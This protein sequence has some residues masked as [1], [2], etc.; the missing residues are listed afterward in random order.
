[1]KSLPIV[2]LMI[3]VFQGISAQDKPDPE[4]KKFGIKFS[5]FVKNDFFVDSRQTICARNGHFLLWPAPVMLDPNG[6]DINAQPTF[7]ILAIQSRLKG[8][9]SGPDAFGAKTSGVIEGD[10]FAQANDNINLLRLRHAFVKLNWPT[11]ELLAGQTWN[12]MFVTE[13]FPGTLSFNTGTPLQSF[14]RNPQIRI[15]YSKGGFKIMGA[16]LSQLDYSTYG[17]EGPSCTYIRNSATPDMHLQFQYGSRNQDSG[18]GINVGGG[19]AYK[20]I[21]PR[22]SSD[23]EGEQYRVNETV[24]G[25]T[26]MVFSK[27]VLTPLTIKLQARY[28]ENISDLLSISGFAVRE[29]TNAS[30]GEQSYTPLQNMSFWGEIHSNGEKFQAGLFGGYLSNMGTKDP[31]SDPGNPVYGLATTI[32]SLMRLAP[33]VSYNAGRVRIAL[34]LEYTK[35]EYGED[36]DIN[37][38]AGQT[39]PVSNIRALAAIYYFF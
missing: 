12:P 27:F 4:E 20:T 30:T 8:T 24:A 37:Y 25:I 21:V 1:M 17:I 15:T 22:L 31:M 5:G 33:R 29:I 2:L 9:I 18:F 3:L 26:G 36:F 38:Q 23:V 35:A 39:V 34:E 16:A 11:L 19:I 10:F 7:N 28:G 6:E 13:C 14:A 32:T